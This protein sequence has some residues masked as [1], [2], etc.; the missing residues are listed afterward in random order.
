MDNRKTRWLVYFVIYGPLLLYLFFVSFGLFG[1]YGLRDD[2]YG[3]IFIGGAMT[4]AG[5]VGPIILLINHFLRKKFGEIVNFK[6]I[7]GFYIVIAIVG[8][9]LILFMYSGVLGILSDNP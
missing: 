9:G 2:F 4:I 1:I 8:I 5:V 3:G 6:I 7:N